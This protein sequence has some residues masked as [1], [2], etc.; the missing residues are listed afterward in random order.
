MTY[1]WD[2]I[3]SCSKITRLLTLFC[4]LTIPLSGSAMAD[5]STSGDSYTTS[6]GADSPAGTAN[7][8]SCQQTP[9]VSRAWTVEN[10][11]TL[12][13]AIL[14]FVASVIATA[15]SI[16]NSRFGR[17][18]SRRWWERKVEAYSKIIG[19]LSELVYYYEERY[20][21]EVDGHNRTDDHKDEIEKQWRKGY[22]EVKRVTA[23]G[24]FLIS[25]EAEAALRKMSKEKG[26]GAQS[27]DLF[28]ILQSDCTLLN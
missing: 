23:I 2:L 24:A 16:Y 22:A 21:A 25:P 28:D 17:F 5:T 27:N 1:R 4:F 18:T 8:I 14:A 7:A 3:L 11:V 20:D 13:A 26:K 12:V 10:V 9:H 19:A 15:V 6:K